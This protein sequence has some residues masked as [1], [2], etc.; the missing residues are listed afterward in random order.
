[1]I[2]REICDFIFPSIL[3]RGDITVSVSTGGSSPVL[4]R[5][6]RT[7]LETM[8]P[9]AYGKVAKIISE[10]RVMVREKLKQSQSNKIFGSRC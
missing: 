7:K 1:M 8:I 2:D 10:N 6:L 4:A 5:M 9:G 3:E